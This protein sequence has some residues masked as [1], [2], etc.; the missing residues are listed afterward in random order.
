MSDAPAPGRLARAA[1][2]LRSLPG[3]QLSR[4]INSRDG[5]RLRTEE[6][7]LTNRSGYRIAAH[8][9]EPDDA[10]LRPAVLLV[11]GAGQPG[12]RFCGIG[13]LLGANEVAALGIRVL[14]FDPVGRGRSWGHDDFSGL[15]G[16]DSLRAALDFL[17]TRRGV[18]RRRVV[19]VSFSMGLSLAAPV[20]ARE[21]LRL[22]TLALI[23][24]EGP[25]TRSALEALGDLPPAAQA[26]CESDPEAFW[27]IREPLRSIGEVPCTYV[28]IQSDV[29]HAAGAAGR[30]GA[31]ELV[32][33]A[34]RGEATTSRLNDNPPDTAW[35][36]DQ[37]E[38]LRWADSSSGSLNRV[39]LREIKALLEL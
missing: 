37:L 5:V 16:Q 28:R 35:R 20:L 9:H 31:L 4:L 36:D 10:E 18:D 30:T 2:H 19:V 26:A 14:H 25:A 21:G 23:D 7:W 6:I 38:E 29:D 24:C 39:L 13:G 1:D 33:A 34:A 3:R 11:P 22:E 27:T 15:E 17:H 12:A 32:R 8:L